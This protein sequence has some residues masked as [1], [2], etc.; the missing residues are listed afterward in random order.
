[1]VLKR[2]ALIVASLAFAALL[3]AYLFAHAFW[4]NLT[5][6]SGSLSVASECA[7]DASGV[8]QSHKVNPNKMLFISCGGFLD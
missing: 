3:N 8:Q 4:S 6:S 5:K 7:P 2:H 1:M